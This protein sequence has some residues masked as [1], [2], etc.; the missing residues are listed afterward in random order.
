MKKT[1]E[2]VDVGGKTVLVRAD[3]NVPLDDGKVTDDFRIRATLPT[4]QYLAQNGARVIL[5]SHLGRPGGKVVEDLRLDPVAA[6]LA[7]LLDQN[8]VK[9]DDCI[10][11]RARQAVDGLEPGQVLLL[12]NTR[13]HPGEKANDPDF[14]AQLAYGAGLYAN[15]AFGAAHRAHA[16]TEGVAHLLPAVA[17][18][19]MARELETLGRVRENPSHPFV[20]ILGGAK[21]SDKIEVVNRLLDQVETLMV[22]GGMANTFLRAQGLETGDSLV[23]EDSLDTAR[24]ILDR[25]GDS[26]VLPVDAVIA[27]AFEAGATHRTVP[28]DQV[29]A[30]WQILD[31]GQRTVDLFK[32]KLSTAK[33]VMWNGPLG[34]FEM[35]AFAQGTMAL[36]KALAGLDAETITGG[37]ET[38][39]AVSQAGVVD[40]LSHVSTGGGAFLEF[41]EGSKLP[42]VEALQ[43]K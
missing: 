30:G 3:F 42:G 43:D 31:V 41:M 26:L 9:T 10:G 27:D 17:G 7:D 35:P 20:A 38:A 34:V 32:D 2:D 21:I 18:L 6:R 8:V 33:M 40:Q 13:F 22:G 25:A 16:S 15:D 29:P 19:L 39:A 11:A 1:I 5:C 4:I 28:V 12:E 36:A 14:A 24:E 23:E 37:G